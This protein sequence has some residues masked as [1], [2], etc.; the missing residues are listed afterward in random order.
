MKT[1]IPRDFK[2]MNIPLC[3][4][5]LDEREYQAV[6]DVLDSGWLTHGLKNIEFEDLFKK[7]IGTRHAIAMNSCT[8]ALHLA[9]E[10][11]GIQGEVILPSFTFVASANAIMLAGATPV[12]ADIEFSSTNIDPASI[13]RMIGPATEAIMPVHYA[14]QCCQM[15]RILEIAKKRHLLVLE[16]SAET[17][18][19]TFNDRQAGSFGIGCFSFFPTKII[20]T[21]EGGMLTTNDDGL[22]EKIRALMAHGILSGTHKREK[23]ERPW[24]R[25]ATYAGYNFRL[26]NLLAALGVVQMGKLQ[27]IIRLRRGHALH[28]NRLLSPELFQLPLESRNCYHVYQM[29]TVKVA[30]G[31]DRNLF[32]LRLREA[33]IGA[34][35][36]FDP[37]VHQ[38]VF[39]KKEFKQDDL[40]VTEKVAERIVTLPLFPTLTEEEIVY[41]ADQANR[42][43]KELSCSKKP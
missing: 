43:A 25:S 8:S 16:D 21:G 34:S 15:D 7:V 39:Y 13:E 18:G 10:A 22:A 28:L 20:T 32:V 38:Q 30:E 17:L 11:H 35:V 24:F 14:G 4:A 2:S 6:K 19:A 40:S 37:P 29:Y 23:E 12:F 33:G 42:I 5:Y 31:I 3:K 26:S 9:L 36:H 1:T 41:M 27:D